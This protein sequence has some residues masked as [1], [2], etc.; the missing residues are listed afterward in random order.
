MRH[1]QIS[2]SFTQSVPD[3]LTDVEDIEV[4]PEAVHDVDSAEEGHLN[5]AIDDSGVHGPQDESGSEDEYFGPG[6]KRPKAAKRHH[7]QLTP[8]EDAVI[9]AQAV[10]EHESIEWT[11][12][13]PFRRVDIL[14]NLKTT[15][16][17][18]SHLSDEV[19]TTESVCL[20]S[21]RLSAV[22]WPN[23]CASW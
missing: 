13:D 1:A 8:E 6:Y 4:A 5:N 23:L 15:D 12:V 10:S 21:I 16:R 3:S 9:Q 18:I 22:D 11:L 19:S 2:E 17:G 7:R 20:A 14:F